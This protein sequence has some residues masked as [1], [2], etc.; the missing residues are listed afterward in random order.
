MAVYGLP[1]TEDNRPRQLELDLRLD[2]ISEAFLAG[3]LASKFP[4]PSTK[5]QMRLL[6]EFWGRFKTD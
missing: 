4:V 5:S 1:K 3:I 6:E 2:P